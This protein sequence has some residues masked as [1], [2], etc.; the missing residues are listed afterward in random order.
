MTTIKIR[1][2]ISINMASSGL[3]VGRSFPMHAVDTNASAQFQPLCFFFTNL[4][5]R[6]LLNN[7][8]WGLT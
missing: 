6:H 3:S 5:D 4:N 1:F 8:V 7:A 2:P